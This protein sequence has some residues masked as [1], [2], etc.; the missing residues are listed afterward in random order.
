M[1]FLLYEIVARIVAI[2]LCIDCYRKLRHGL[3]EGKIASFSP[4]PVNWFLELFQDPSYRVAHR[5]AAPIRYWI[6][7]GFRII[8]LVACLFV[9]ILGWWHPN[10]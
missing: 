3:A 2:Y 5:D 9:A 4:D 6:E 7:M 10:T 8:S 1:Q